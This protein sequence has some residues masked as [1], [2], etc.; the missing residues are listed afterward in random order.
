MI[1]RKKK[2][3]LI[4]YTLFLLGALVVILSYTNMKSAKIIPVDQKNY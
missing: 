3:K 1:D 4:Q 2:I